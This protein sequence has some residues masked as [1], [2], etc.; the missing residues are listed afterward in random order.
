MN[1]IKETGDI[2]FAFSDRK[3][4]LEG[5]VVRISMIGFDDG[6][7]GLKILDKKAVNSI[8]SNLTAGANTTT[9]VPLSENSGICFMGASPKGEFDISAE[10]ARKML[11][12]PRNI[13]GRQNSDVVRPVVSGIDIVGSSRHRW[14]IDFGTDL[15][16]DQAAQ[17]EMPFEYVKAAV[18]PARM[19]NNRESYRDRWWLYGKHDLE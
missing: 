14:T 11:N 4:P 17:Y 13:N 15:T 2:F 10:V 16:E 5:A 7:E 12:A 6:S 18:Y 9:A 1:R 19:S 8:H 3:W